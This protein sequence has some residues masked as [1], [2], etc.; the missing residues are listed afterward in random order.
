VEEVSEEGVLEIIKYPDV[1]ILLLKGSSER[2]SCLGCR[3][4]ALDRWAKGARKMK[5]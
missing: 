2:V 5:G 4:R 1:S 3:K